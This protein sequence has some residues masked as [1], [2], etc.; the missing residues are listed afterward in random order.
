[1]VALRTRRTTFAVL[2]VVSA[3]A[4]FAVGSFA[5][6]ALVQSEADAQATAKALAAAGVAS[7]LEPEDLAEP[8]NGTTGDDLLDRLQRGVLADGTVFRIRI[9]SPEG[10]LLFSTDAA[11]PSDALGDLPSIGTATKGQGRPISRVVDNESFETYVPLRLGE[12]NALGAVQVDQGYAPIAAKAATPWGLLRTVSVAV[13]AVCLLLVIIATLPIGVARNGGFGAAKASRKRTPKR[14]KAMT[15]G[16]S[17]KE[18][19]KVQTRA[20]RAEA[21]R[22]EMEGQLEQLRAQIVS[23]DENAGRTI[24]ELQEQLKEAL[25]REEQARVREAAAVHAPSADPAAD[26]RNRQRDEE[27]NQLQARAEA[28]ETRVRALES[29]V[30]T[31]EAAAA[32]PTEAGDPEEVEALRAELAEAHDRAERGSRLAE[33]ADQTLLGFEARVQ[34]L[35]GALASARSQAADAT[36]KLDEARADTER[37]QEGAAE[38]TEAA[39]LIAEAAK[40]VAAAEDAAEDALTRAG[41][42]EARAEEATVRAQESDARAAEASEHG[43][44]VDERIAELEAELERA[45]IEA[46]QAPSSA[47]E[48][49]PR[50]DDR[51]VELAAAQIRASEAERSARAAQDRADAAQRVAVESEALVKEAESRVAD[52]E[53]RVTEAEGRVTEA[54]GRV[55]EAEATTGTTTDAVAAAEDHAAQLQAQLDELTARATETERTMRELEARAQRAEEVAESTGADLSARTTRLGEADERIA[56]LEKELSLAASR[57]ERADEIEGSLETTSARAAELESLA[58]EATDRVAEL[59]A[60][61]QEI[62]SEAQ[63]AVEQADAEALARE[64]EIATAHRAALDQATTDADVR[65]EQVREEAAA[66]AGAL[67]DQARS[68]ARARLAS[69]EAELADADAREKTLETQLVEHRTEI[70]DS[71]AAVAEVEARVAEAT[72]LGDQARAELSEMTAA[73]IAGEETDAD[74]RRRIGDLELRAAEATASAQASRVEAEDA[75]AL[76]ESTQAEAAAAIETA[77]TEAAAAVEVARR[78]AVEAV[79]RRTGDVDD[80]SMPTVDGSSASPPD[81]GSGEEVVALQR[82]VD[83]LEEQLEQMSER[84]RHAYAQAES[85]QAAFST[86]R[87]SGDLPPADPE[88]RTLSAEVDRLR[89][90]LGTSMAA[91]ATAEERAARF[92]ADLIASQKGVPLEQSRP[93][94]GYEPPHEPAMRDREPESSTSA[95]DAGTGGDPLEEDQPERELSLRSRLA[96]TAARKKQRGRPNDSASGF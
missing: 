62:R 4:F 49:P 24:G 33:T 22:E 91:Q 47:H 83:D 48:T 65:L 16:A 18:V 75:R 20:D 46:Q 73:A 11:D 58:R 94:P 64:A 90:Q 54:E 96:N 25:E 7:V 39:E 63:A 43:S 81:A 51:G 85:V 70:E 17:P 10:D 59:E 3:I 21:A 5:S 74:L 44:Q 93:E 72:M 19:A 40:R 52:A 32:A 57:A 37:S 92:E 87:Q 56:D 35:E 71:H 79:R 86:A 60:A 82:T 31:L 34:E 69:L 45:A 29:T 26:E 27:T 88:V 89:A 42:A 95:D 6:R 50:D 28:A 76:T 14:A 84:L 41:A 15:A 77:Q 13:G 53:G 9:W 36:A 12:D 80:A 55:A 30:E 61:T 67:V 1:M 38:A 8:V 68:E 66:E 2:V 78:E 23:A